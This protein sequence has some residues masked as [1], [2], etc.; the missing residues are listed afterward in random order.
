[1]QGSGRYIRTFHG[2]WGLLWAY[3][4][5]LGPDSP[6]IIPACE[7]LRSLRAR[8]TMHHAGYLCFPGCGSSSQRYHAH[9]RLGRGH[10][11]RTDWCF[12]VHTAD[13]GEF[14]ALF[15]LDV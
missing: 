12:D 2:N 5:Y 4:W 11:V 14:E 15:D 3:G 7:V 13:N 1:M 6:R 10:N 9:Y 8:P